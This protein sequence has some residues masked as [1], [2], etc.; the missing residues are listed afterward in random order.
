[1]TLVPVVA[2]D[3]QEFVRRILDRLDDLRMRMT[4]R[5][6]GNTAH[7]VEEAIAD[8]E[9]NCDIVDGMLKE[10]ETALPLKTAAR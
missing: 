1:M 3:V 2:R 5:T 10:R 7:E 4:G 6:N 9:R 8:L